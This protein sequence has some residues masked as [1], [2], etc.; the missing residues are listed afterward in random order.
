M[1]SN[2]LLKGGGWGGD[3]IG[4]VSYS[5]PDGMVWT[6]QRE[7]EGVRQDTKSISTTVRERNY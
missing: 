3:W 7:S 6:P 5:T 4:V 1:R 2:H